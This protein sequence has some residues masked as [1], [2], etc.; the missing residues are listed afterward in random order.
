MAIRGYL[1]NLRRVEHVS[2]SV[3]SFTDL[4]ASGANATTLYITAR[5]LLQGQTINTV[6]DRIVNII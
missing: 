2:H 5:A 6:L 1:I 3:F 4:S